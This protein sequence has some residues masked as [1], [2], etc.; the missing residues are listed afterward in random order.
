MSLPPFVQYVLRAN[1]KGTISTG[2]T[3]L[4]LRIAAFALQRSPCMLF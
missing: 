2:F 3:T 1:K 4:K